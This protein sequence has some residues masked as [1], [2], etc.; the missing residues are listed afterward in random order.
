[1]IDRAEVL[2]QMP[3]GPGFVIPRSMLRHREGAVLGSPS[4]G[5]FAVHDAARGTLALVGSPR[6][7]D[8]LPSLAPRV[9]FAVSESFDTAFWPNFHWQSLAVFSGGTQGREHRP[10][11]SSRPSAAVERLSPAFE[12]SS[13]PEGLRFALKV[14]LSLGPVYAIRQQN[15][16]V[17]T[18]CCF[19]RS[20][21]YFDISID[22][23]SSHRRR[24]F[25][26]WVAAALLEE[27]WPA[28]AVHCSAEEETLARAFVRSLGL[29]R[30]GRIFRGVVRERNDR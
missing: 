13:A 5:D 17:A 26:R 6:P 20:G 22:T 3:D 9:V 2:R 12:I 21:R 11:A 28:E 18:A 16:V 24:G 27:M 8:C 30:V 29:R 19:W 1:M 25:G 23:V 10:G 7:E 14:G 15:K 4:S